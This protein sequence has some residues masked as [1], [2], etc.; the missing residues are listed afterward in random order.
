MF[1]TL[2]PCTTDAIT[3]VDQHNNF[4]MI[5]ALVGLPLELDFVRYKILLGSTVPNYEVGNEKLLCLT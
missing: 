4:F 5:M 2:I 3:H 1:T